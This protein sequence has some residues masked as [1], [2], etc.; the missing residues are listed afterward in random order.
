MI[1][2]CCN[3]LDCTKFLIDDSKTISDRRQ[4]REA[5]VLSFLMQCTL[6]E[7]SN[8]LDSDPTF[9]L[10]EV[11][12]QFL[13]NSQVQN[14]VVK[15]ESFTLKVSYWKI[16]TRSYILTKVMFSWWQEQHENHVWFLSPLTSFK[17]SCNNLKNNYNLF[18]IWV[19]N[20]WVSFNWMMA[21]SPR[22]SMHQTN[23]S[24]IFLIL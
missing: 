18:S 10:A 17:S 7:Y 5:R 6:K 4:S 11:E 22:N 2:F 1:N 20:Q 23:Y 12:D 3:S 13:H 15:F 8:N 14:K 21:V 24:W 19:F 16:Q 9:A